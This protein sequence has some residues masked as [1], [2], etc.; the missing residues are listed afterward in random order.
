VSV[1]K[2]KWQ[3][4]CRA[5]KVLHTLRP[6][7]YLGILFLA[8]IQFHA[9]L[10]HSAKQTTTCID[11]LAGAE[12]RMMCED[13]VNGAS[14]TS[15]MII[16]LCQRRRPFKSNLFVTS[17][18]LVSHQYNRHYIA[19]SP[20]MTVRWKTLTSAS[21]ADVGQFGFVSRVNSTPEGCVDMWIRE[22]EGVIE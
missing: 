6:E 19:Q 18:V 5:S 4:S 1:L 9:L 7:L 20:V 10:I 14:N 12:F 15:F 11:A 2:Q 16:G 13:P 21:Y 17:A 8:C 22:L 3:N